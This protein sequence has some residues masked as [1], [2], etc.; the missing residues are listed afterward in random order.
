MKCIT[1][2][3]IPKAREKKEFNIG[4]EAKPSPPGTT[5]HIEMIVQ[6]NGII[7]NMQITKAEA[8]ELRNLLNASILELAGFEDRQRA[9]RKPQGT[10]IR[11]L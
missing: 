10:P 3:L 9:N 4:F 8:T 6:Y 5:Q 7:F 1:R 11:K 2:W